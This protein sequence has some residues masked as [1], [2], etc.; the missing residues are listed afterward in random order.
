MS[1]TF[2]AAV[3]ACCVLVG[4][5]A[6]SAGP[7]DAA[8]ARISARRLLLQLPTRQESGSGYRRTYFG[9]WSDFDHDSC[10]TRLEVLIAES[11]T[12]PRVGASCRLY[13]G[14]WVSPYDNVRATTYGGFDIDHMVPLAEAWGSGARAWNAA[15][16]AAFANDLGY[17]YS[18]NAV[19]ARSNRSKGDKEPGSWLP[20][21][22]AYRCT[23]LASWV[24]VKWRW[25]LSVDPSERAGLTRALGACGAGVL[26]E[27]PTRARVVLAPAPRP[28]APRPVVAPPRPP[29]GNDPD[30]GTCGAVIAAGLGPYRRG[31]DPEYAWYQDRDGDGIVC[32]R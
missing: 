11:L 28:P 18:L 13:G 19:T 5:V 14:T 27:Q 30:L 29:S 22:R 6:A 4:S 2:R 12:R 25:G 16:R 7:A 3:V 1:R 9:D 15:T 26:V 31:I 23:Y 17:R 32:E 20:S 10:N 8:P 21:N 24:A